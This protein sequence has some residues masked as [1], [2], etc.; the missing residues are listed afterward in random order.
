[1]K[2]YF[3]PDLG[4]WVTICPPGTA[5]AAD[6][7]RMLRDAADRWLKAHE[8][9]KLPNDRYGNP[10]PLNKAEWGRASPEKRWAS[11]ELAVKLRKEQRRQRRKARQVIS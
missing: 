2:R 1:M 11:H 6:K 4:A 9:P 5:S 10:R 7:R 8:L 3:D